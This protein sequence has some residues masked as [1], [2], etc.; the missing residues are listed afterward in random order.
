MFMGSKEIINI[1]KFLKKYD[2][3]SIAEN[4]TR[5]NITYQVSCLMLWEDGCFVGLND[6][7]DYIIELSNSGIK[8]FIPCSVSVSIKGNLMTLHFSD[9]IVTV[10]GS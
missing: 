3:F 5:S 4:F 1:K 8:G 10:K 7:D 2:F 6:V 9:G